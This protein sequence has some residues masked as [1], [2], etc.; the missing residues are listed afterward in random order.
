ML[1]CTGGGNE[2]VSKQAALW[3]HSVVPLVPMVTSHK[4]EFPWLC[5]DTDG[6]AIILA[7]ALSSGR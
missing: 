4:A 2:D 1:D 7:F 5:N 3:S 6:F